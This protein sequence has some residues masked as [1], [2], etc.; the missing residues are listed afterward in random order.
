[1][2]PYG[3]LRV[4]EFV[5]RALPPWNS[6]EAAQ[7][8]SYALRVIPLLLGTLWYRC[9]GIAPA[10]DA[11]DT[12]LS[13]DQPC[14]ARRHEAPVV[15]EQGHDASL[16]PGHPQQ[17]WFLRCDWLGCGDC[18]ERR[19]LK[20]GIGRFSAE[21]FSLSALSVDFRRTYPVVA[22]R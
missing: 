15:I 8:V 18:R 22:H 13:Q 5:S 20:G 16:Q 21:F 4:Q 3:V 9:L 1:M 19:Y 7:V 17:P 10:W 11:M 6:T 14:A 12:F 2:D